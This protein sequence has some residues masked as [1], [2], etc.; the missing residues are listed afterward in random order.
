MKKTDA[1]IAHETGVTTLIMG[2][3]LLACSASASAATLPVS[4]YD[5][6]NGAASTPG[7]SLRDDTY[8]GGTGNPGVDYSTLAGGKGDLTDG[9]VAANNWNITPAEF[10]GWSQYYVP[11]PEITFHFAQ[12][13]DISDVSIHMNWGY[14]ASSVD[15]SVDRTTWINRV[16][17]LP[18]PPTGANFQAGF[19]GLGLTGD[20]LVMR[21]NDRSPFYW[22]S[23]LVSA[24]W[25]LISEVSIEGSLAPIPEPTVT[26]LLLAGIGIVCF[27]ARRRGRPGML[28]G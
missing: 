22:N 13:M 2:A 17:N 28:P 5:M 25:I 16:I 23:T 24:D 9:L 12:V 7:L 21:L 26:S 18:D 14:S 20:T 15:F 27:A 19:A 1:R 11:N 4:S 6:I 8:T 3:A 10:V